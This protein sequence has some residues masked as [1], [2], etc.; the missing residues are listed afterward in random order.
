VNAKT[1]QELL[2]AYAW[3]Q[4]E[5]AFAELVRRHI[6]LVYSAALRLVVDPHLAEDATQGTFIA[7]A[8]NAPKLAAREVL[9]SWLHLTARNMAA[10][11]VRSEERRRAQPPL[12]WGPARGG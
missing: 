8:Q 9:S 4:S 5:A 11:L 10:K 7:L 6:H 1:D 2:R 12:P 3:E